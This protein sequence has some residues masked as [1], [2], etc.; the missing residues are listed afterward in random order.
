MLS[1]AQEMNWHIFLA[2]IDIL[3]KEEFLQQGL[4]FFP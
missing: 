2:M 3:E 1:S 4:F